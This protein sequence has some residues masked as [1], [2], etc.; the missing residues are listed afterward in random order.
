[1]GEFNFTYEG[2]TFDLIR[3][4][5]DLIDVD[6]L[7]YGNSDYVETRTTKTLDELS[8]LDSAHIRKAF[9][10][11]LEVSFD[12]IMYDINIRY[13]E[14]ISQNDDGTFTYS[15]IGFESWIDNEL[16]D[17]TLNFQVI[18]DG[19]KRDLTNVAKSMLLGI[20]GIHVLD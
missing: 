13:E 15:S 16:Y 12:E 9:E 20:P 17:Y 8:H 5:Y 2:S 10:E 1:M 11:E 3:E 6:I 7:A 18:D 14:F 19:F 4:L